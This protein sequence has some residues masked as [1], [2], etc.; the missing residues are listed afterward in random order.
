MLGKKAPE[1]QKE[2][3]AG[4]EALVQEDVIAGYV[5]KPWSFGTIIK[6]TA[7]LNKVADKF[8]QSGISMGSLK[9]NDTEA[10]AKIIQIVMPIAPIIMSTTLDVDEEVITNLPADDGLLIMLTITKQNV[11]YLKNLFGPILNLITELTAVINLTMG[12]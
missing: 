12:S 10:I 9:E 11:K 2:D 3:V 8:K 1:K 6:L 5:I 4:A 7:H